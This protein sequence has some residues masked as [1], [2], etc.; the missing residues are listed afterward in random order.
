MKTLVAIAVALAASIPALARAQTPPPGYYA[1]PPPPGYYAPPPGAYA[2]PPSTGT[3]MIVTGSVFTG[4]G[5]INLATSPVCLTIQD[6]GTQTFCLGLSIGVG[7][8]FAAIGIPLLVVGAGRR[9]AY[10][11]W[12][13]ENGVAA[14]LTDLGFEPARGGGTATWHLTF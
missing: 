6:S 12:K 3:G 4:L 8:A 13:K 2:T 9:R 10:L 11:E 5:F 1:P 7:V 14:H